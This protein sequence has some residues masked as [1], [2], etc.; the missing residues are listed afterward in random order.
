MEPAHGQAGVYALMKEPVRLEKLRTNLVVHAEHKPEPVATIANGLSGV[1]AQR[2]VFVHPM[3][4]RQRQRSAEIAGLVVVQEPALTRVVG[5]TGL[6]GV[7]VQ[8]PD[9]VKPASRS[10]KHVG[11]AANARETVARFVYGVAG[12][13]VRTKAFVHRALCKFRIAE[14][15]GP[16]S[17]HVRIH[18]NGMSGTRA[19]PKGFAAQER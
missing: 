4:L 15:A 5:A 7:I 9:S 6:T 17:V 3:R 13:N 14:T 2:V 11:I 10:W 19:A 16:N 1:N 18:V 12:Q 8:E